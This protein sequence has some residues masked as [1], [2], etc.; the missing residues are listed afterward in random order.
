MKKNSLGPIFI[1]GLDRSGKTLL[2]LALSAH[3]RLALSR[4]TYFWTQI[5][6]RYGNLGEERN[7]ERCLQDLL[8]K[9][10]VRSLQPDE[11]YLRREFARGEP[12]Y[13]RLLA[14]LHEHFAAQVGKERWGMQET[15]IEEHADEIFAAFPAARL[16]HL[17]RDPR[18]RYEEILLSAAPGQHLGRT[19]WVTAEWRRSVTLARQ[20][21]SRFA[22]RYKI[23]LYEQLIARPE[24][25]LREICAFLEEDFSPTMLTLEGALGLGE[26]GETATH[27]KSEW[28]AGEATFAWGR[29]RAISPVEVAFIQKYADDEMRWFGYS[30]TSV[31]L[32]ASEQVRYFLQWPFNFLR[33]FI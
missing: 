11:A 29:M 24:E 9:K 28:E 5:Y 7:F 15:E 32:S 17:V 6:N 27:P 4:R 33:L 23:V 22:G 2:R 1:G 21:A 16:I 31:S 25:T 30:L 20:N 8:A 26:A 3:P 14:L 13:E 12:T 19:G 10:A 18:C